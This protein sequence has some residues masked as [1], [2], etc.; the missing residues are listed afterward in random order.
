MVK[1]MLT[2]SN[3]ISLLRGPLALLFLFD[4]VKIRVF[5]I[6]AAMISDCIDGYLA[7][8]FKSE[9]FLGKVLDPVM[10]KFFVY[11]VLGVLT[12]QHTISGFA[13]FAFLAR[14]ISVFL[15]VMTTLAIQGWHQIVFSP[16]ISS[17]IT[18]ALQFVTLFAIV[19]KFSPPPILYYIFLGLAPLIYIEL[20]WGTFFK[21]KNKATS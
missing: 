19:L 15:Y 10:D 21:K 13:L 4:S 14:D 16:A 3:T 5:A 7:R 1:N 17:K 2:L 20:L 6:I 9:T 12:Y 8:K 11:F 18:T